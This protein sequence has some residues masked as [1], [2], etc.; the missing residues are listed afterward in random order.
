MYDALKPLYLETDAGNRKYEFGYDEIPD[1]VTPY[2]NAFARR[3]L[4]HAEQQSSKIEWEAL[5]I[6]HGSKKFHH[7]YFTKDVYIITDHKPLVAVVNRDV[8]T[9]SQQL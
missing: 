4:S 3:I 5:G 2:L 6:L 7:Y 9:L 8:A 1:N